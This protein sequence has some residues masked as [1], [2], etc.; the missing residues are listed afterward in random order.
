MAILLGFLQTPAAHKPWLSAWHDVHRFH[1]WVI[2]GC[3]IALLLAA[4]GVVRWLAAVWLRSWARRHRDHQ[5]SEVVEVCVQ[6]LTPVLLVALFSVALNLLD[7]PPAVLSRLNKWLSIAILLLV[8]Y[9]L[10]KLL[11]LLLTRQLAAQQSSIR[12]ESVQ[13]FTR[14][15][16]G[17]VAMLIVLDN[18][19]KIQFRTIWTTL[20]VGGVA[21]ALALQDTLSNFF[22]GI[23]LRLDNPVQIGDYVLLEGSQEG[24]VRELGWRSTRLR[25]LADNVVIIPNAKLASTVVINYS[26]PSAEHSV[27]VTV[28]LEGSTDTQSVKKVLVEEAERAQKELPGFL[29]EIPP[30]A[31]FVPKLGEKLQTYV[32][33]CRVSSDADQFALREKLRQR[34]VERLEREGWSVAGAP[35]PEPRG[36]QD[37]SQPAGEQQNASPSASK[38]PATSQQ[39]DRPLDKVLG[40]KT[41]NR[42]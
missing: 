27:M 6:G 22:A 36:S 34:L 21:I 33:W 9:F 42:S 7:L 31:R 15:I 28:K 30:R 1:P 12:S 41:D 24:F 3:E 13:F 4:F 25:T 37:G 8:L 20:G 2:Y 5:H 17:L 38:P 29:A 26:A 11:Q 23:Y 18:Q 35:K 14:L 16:F 19:T 10:L 39:P 32:L 40:R